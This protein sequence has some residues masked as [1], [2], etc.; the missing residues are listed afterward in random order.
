MGGGGVREEESL[1]VYEKCSVKHLYKDST[2]DSHPLEFRV[3]E[4]AIFDE[5]S[6]ENAYSTVVLFL[7]RGTELSAAET[8]WLEWAQKYSDK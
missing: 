2:L 8:I 7:H 1:W 4:E 3:L 6:F 5:Q